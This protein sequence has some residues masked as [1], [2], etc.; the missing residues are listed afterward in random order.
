MLAQFRCAMRYAESSSTSFIQLLGF[1]KKYIFKNR[2]ISKLLNWITQEYVILFFRDENYMDEV[3]K[4]RIFPRQQLPPGSE[5]MSSPTRPIASPTLIL[6]SIH[7]EMELTPH[8]KVCRLGEIHTSSSP[9]PRPFLEGGQYLRKPAGVN[10]LIKK[11]FTWHQPAS[12]GICF[13]AL[14]IFAQILWYMIVFNKISLFDML[15]NL[16]CMI[17]VDPQ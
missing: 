15:L 7:N 3:Y 4:H 16:A 11:F 6:E 5:I 14:F 8:H 9:P 10:H 1:K 13:S 17:F 12:V 2:I